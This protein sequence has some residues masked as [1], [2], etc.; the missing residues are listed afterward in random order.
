MVAVALLVVSCGIE[1]TP[2]TSP[3]ATPTYPPSPLVA[4]DGGDRIDLEAIF[5]FVAENWDTC[6]M[7]AAFVVSLIAGGVEQAKSAGVSLMLEAEKIARDQVRMGGPEKMASVV[8]HVYDSLPLQAKSVI[9]AYA[10]VK[11]VS[12]QMLLDEL[13]QKWYDKAVNA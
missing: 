11:G 7:V 2:T 4:Q 8:G 3:L 1:S 5:R 12:V 6:V 9:K 13:C 10:I